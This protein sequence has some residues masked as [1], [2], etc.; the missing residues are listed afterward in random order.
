MSNNTPITDYEEA[1]RIAEEKQRARLEEAK[2]DI[3][4]YNQITNPT[5]ETI[6]EGYVPDE[7]EPTPDEPVAEQVNRMINI[8]FKEG[9]DDMDAMQTT[10][11]R[12]GFDALF[13]TH[14]QLSSVSSFTP[15]QWKKFITDPRVSAFIN[16]EMEL[17]KKAKV[18]TMLRES[19]H[20]KNVGQAQL[21]NTLLNQTKGL[22]K[23]DGP[24]FVY[25]WVPL[26]EN[27]QHAENVEVQDVNLTEYFK[28]QKRQDSI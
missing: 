27:E 11:N 2:R 23:K 17:L 28:N 20:N 9:E 12:L 10:Y 25:C 14:Y 13:M 6:Y 5:V 24:A 18:A 19:D 3:L 8:T 7:T 21:L 4:S 1:M 22:D 16:E 15:I 26:N